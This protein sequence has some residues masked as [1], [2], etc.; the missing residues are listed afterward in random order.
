M[1]ASAAIDDTGIKYEP[2]EIKDA[3]TK[4]DP[5]VTQDEKLIIYFDADAAKGAMT[6][7]QVRIMEDFVLLQ[8]DLVQQARENPDAKPVPDEGLR[9]RFSKLGDQIRD[10]D[11]QAG[12]YWMLPPAFAWTDVCG[13]SFD[14]HHPEYVRKVVGRYDTKQEAVAF[15]TGQG[16]HEVAAYA[17]LH[18]LNVDIVDTARFTNEYNCTDDSFRDQIVINGEEEGWVLEEQIKEP[19][20]EFLVY[21]HP[22]W[23][24]TFY[25]IEWH[26]VEHDDPV[27]W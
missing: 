11:L 24:W 1:L 14:N 15:V 2:S 5:Y 13:G 3:F 20:P 12:A 23:W 21:I 26:V 9:D 7:R 25:V 17:S 22:A 4:A 10:K 8:N 6:E 18:Y 16:Y 27:Y 19:N